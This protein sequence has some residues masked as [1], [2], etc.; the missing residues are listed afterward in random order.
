MT[1]I[2]MIVIALISGVRKETLVSLR[3]ISR[4]TLGA[5]NSFACFFFSFGSEL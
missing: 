4:I 5:F 2:T 1:L 3:N